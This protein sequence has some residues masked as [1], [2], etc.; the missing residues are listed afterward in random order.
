M[1][2]YCV[3][4]LTDI[5]WISD[6]A[7]YYTFESLE[8]YRIGLDIIRVRKIRFYELVQGKSLV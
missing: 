4:V 6:P 7:I 5:Q 2:P 8:R 3:I 1:K